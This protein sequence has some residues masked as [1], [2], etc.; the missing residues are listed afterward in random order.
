[1]DGLE[2]A[3]MEADAVQRRVERLQTDYVRCIDGERY[4]EWPD[5]FTERCLYRVISRDNYKRGMPVGFLFCDSRGMLRDRIASMRRANIYEPH[6]YR[7]AVSATVAEPD[8]DGGW[9]SETSYILA[10]IMHDGRQELFSTGRYVDRIVE[11]E[12]RLRFKERTVVCDSSRIDSLMVI[13]I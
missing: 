8:G 10:R 7:H 1:M 2:R 3:S 11:D 6:S 5:F 13:P 9:R 4:E 12:G